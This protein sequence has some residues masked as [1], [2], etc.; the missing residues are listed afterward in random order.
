MGAEGTRAMQDSFDFIVI[1]SGSGGA[2]VARRLAEA[3]AEVLVLEA[4]R[5]PKGVREIAQ[6]AKLLAD[7]ATQVSQG[8]FALKGASESLATLAAQ[9]NENARGFRLQ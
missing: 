6:N 9:L 5:D 3:G 2:P 8:A 1:G 4:G 7:D